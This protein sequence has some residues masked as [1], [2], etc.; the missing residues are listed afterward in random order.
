MANQPG[1]PRVLILDDGTEHIFKWHAGEP[2]EVVAVT[3]DDITLNLVSGGYIASQRMRDLARSASPDEYDYVIIGNYLGLGL[4]LGR[5][6]STQLRPHTLI[7]WNVPPTD[8]ETWEYRE[9][10]YQHFGTRTA[11]GRWYNKQV[12]RSMTS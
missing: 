8:T 2:S 11:A 6:L 9:M 1:P 3:T 5:I 12:E 4:T 7:V 10:G